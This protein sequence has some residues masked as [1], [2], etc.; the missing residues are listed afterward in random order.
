MVDILRAET[1]S[2]TLTPEVVT[3]TDMKKEAGCDISA[4]PLNYFCL[5]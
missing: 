5:L 3:N 2:F 4:R 1:D